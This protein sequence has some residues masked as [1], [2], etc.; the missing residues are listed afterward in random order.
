[1][2]PGDPF[3]TEEL[4]HARAKQ[5]AILSALPLGALEQMVPHPLSEELLSTLHPRT[6]SAL[7]ELAVRYIEEAHQVVADAHLVAVADAALA[8][9]DATP[10]AGADD[11]NELR[12]QLEHHR[13]FPKV[14]ELHY[15]DDVLRALRVLVPLLVWADEIAGDWADDRIP[16]ARTTQE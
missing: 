3:L 13:I 14:V 11:L 7:R 9:I 4:D 10:A 8:A 12:Q 15:H 6:E 2:I 1:M 16:A 5:R